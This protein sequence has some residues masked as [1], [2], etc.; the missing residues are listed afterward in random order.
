M[1]PLHEAAHLGDAEAFQKLIAEGVDPNQR[2]EEGN[3]ALHAAAAFRYDRRTVIEIL[4]ALGGE[5]NARNTRGETALHL[6][7]KG[8]H[9]QHRGWDFTSQ[10][11]KWVETAEALI[12]HGADVNAKD[13]DQ[14]TP[15]DWA[16]TIDDL[17]ER[18]VDLLRRHGGVAMQRKDSK[19]AQ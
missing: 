5:V 7:C 12:A 6:A 10:D 2:D 18:I 15:L 9:P 11:P 17:D 8:P 16:L 1:P 14:K 4:I 3:T 19:E 13:Q